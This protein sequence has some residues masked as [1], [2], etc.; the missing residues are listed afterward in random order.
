MQRRYSLEQSTSRYRPL[1]LPF[2]P[3]RSTGCG[4]PTGQYRHHLPYPRR[5]PTPCQR[6]EDHSEYYPWSSEPSSAMPP[7]LAAFLLVSPYQ[8]PCTL[9]AARMVTKVNATLSQFTGVPCEIERKHGEAGT[10]TRKRP[11]TYVRAREAAATSR[12]PSPGL[13]KR[14]SAIPPSATCLF[15]TKKG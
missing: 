11:R 6:W 3:Q 10:A 14:T 4:R 5:G 2:A 1:R 15:V 9:P 8:D 12:E 13:S 7:L